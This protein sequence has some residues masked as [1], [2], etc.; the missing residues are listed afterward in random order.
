MAKNNKQQIIQYVNKKGVLVTELCHDPL[1]CKKH[2]KRKRIN[3]GLTLTQ[4]IAQNPML[5]VEKEPLEQTLNKV[6]YCDNKKELEVYSHHDDLMVRAAVVKNLATSPKTIEKLA[7]DNEDAVSSLALRDYRLPKKFFKR[8]SEAT[9]YVRSILAENPSAPQELIEAASRSTDVKV[10]QA[11]ASNF[12][13]SSKVLAQLAHDEEWLVRSSVA[14]NSNTD[15]ETL[16]MLS[17]DV[18]PIVRANV[19]SNASSYENTIVGLSFDK[20]PQVRNSIFL[21]P[22]AH[23]TAKSIVSMQGGK[24]AKTVAQILAAKQS[25]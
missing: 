22:N 24:I 2:N 10:R 3:T 8:Y 23:E 11:A 17:K 4:L 5:F 14:H 15:P 7:L 16:N 12:K 18:Q 9:D 19:M 25:S 20:E 13:A 1:T 21:N 6:E